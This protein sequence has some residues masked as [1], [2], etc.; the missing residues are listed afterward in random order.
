VGGGLVLVGYNFGVEVEWAGFKAHPANGGEIQLLW[1]QY[2][3]YQIGKQSHV[4]ESFVRSTLSRTSRN[5]RK[6]SACAKLHA[7]DDTKLGRLQDCGGVA[8]ERSS[9]RV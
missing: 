2:V 9:V 6:Y 7:P 4:P 8:L 1:I 3:S 5:G